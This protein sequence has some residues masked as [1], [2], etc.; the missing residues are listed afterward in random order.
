M[1]TP[2]DLDRAIDSV[3]SSMMTREPSHGLGSAVMAR[4]RGEHASAPRGFTWHTAAA[5][6]VVC[7]G[8]AMALISQTATVVPEPRGV[9]LTVG[10]PPVIPS[11]S[12][13]LVMEPTPPRRAIRIVRSARTVVRR[14]PL[15]LGDASP[16]EPI[17]TDPI[18]LS[19]IDV[20]QLTREATAMDT[21]N[22]EPLTIEPLA[23]S[24]D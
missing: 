7:G 21:L 8:I 12:A 5:S 16:I 14:A 17:Q 9:R 1:I 6:L 15:P 3:A 13:A 4:V 20:P 2:R 23:A 22:I 19:S 10:Q 18:V 24:N 11:A